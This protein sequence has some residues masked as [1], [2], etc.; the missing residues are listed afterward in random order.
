MCPPELNRSRVLEL[1]VLHDLAEVET[2]DV[3][4]HDGVGPEEKAAL[5]REALSDL[6]KTVPY[7][8][9]FIAVFEEYQQGST[10]EARWVKSVDK[11]EMT[12]QSRT[13][14]EDY[15]VDLQEFRDSSRKALETLGIALEL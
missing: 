12:L 5:E 4:P 10:A 3:T 8:P 15:G 13:Y 2:G 1:A 6:L 7:S 9:Y 14:E 11:L